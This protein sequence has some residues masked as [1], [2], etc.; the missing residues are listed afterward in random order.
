MANQTAVRDSQRKDDVLLAYP[1]G[2]VKIWKGSL[3][4]VNS[5]GYVNRAVTTD[6]RVVG[7]AYETIDNTAGSNG[8]ATIRV[9]RNGTHV[10]NCSGLTQA[11]VGDKVYVTDDNT[12]QTS[13]TST[14]VVGVVTEF[15][16]STSV[17]VKV[18]ADA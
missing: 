14:I 2:A 3:V 16:S 8:S 17:R 4:S 1:M 15:L 7:V 9:D 18:T 11:N 5:S 13:A 12:V 6:K 10:F